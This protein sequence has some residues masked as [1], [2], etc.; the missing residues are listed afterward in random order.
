MVWIS[1]PNWNIFSSAWSI[2]PTVPKSEAHNLDG[3]VIPSGA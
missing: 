3:L 1:K 2:M